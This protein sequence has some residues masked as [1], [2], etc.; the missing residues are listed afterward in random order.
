[1]R[2]FLGW[3]F[4]GTLALLI[5]LIA[6]AFVR[7][8]VRGPLRPGEGQKECLHCARWVPVDAEACPCGNRRFRR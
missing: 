5:A 8:P 3:F 7:G 2:S 4:F 1:M 6:L